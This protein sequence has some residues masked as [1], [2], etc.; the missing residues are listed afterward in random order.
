MIDSLIFVW[1]INLSLSNTFTLNTEILSSSFSTSNGGL[2]SFL[3]YLTNGC[4]LYSIIECS[5]ILLS[6]SLSLNLI[7]VIFAS[8]A[9][10]LLELSL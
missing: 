6:L 1:I 10:F 7:H 8:W 5:V 9:F 3:S 2:L 4:I